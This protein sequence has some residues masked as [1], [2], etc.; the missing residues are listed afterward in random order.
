MAKQRKSRR[1]FLNAAFDASRSWQ[2]GQQYARDAMLKEERTR[3]ERMRQQE[4]AVNILN[5]EADIRYKNARTQL[6]KKLLGEK[7]DSA[8]ARGITLLGCTPC[9]IY[10]LNNPY[11]THCT[12][13][14][15]PLT[16][17]IIDLKG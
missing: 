17:S 8:P 6:L 15:L 13:C 2:K 9:G 3:T 4:I 11:A 14:G 12:E 10:D 5:K 1:G 7:G 16:H